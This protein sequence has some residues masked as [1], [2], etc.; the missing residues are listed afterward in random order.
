MAN[1]EAEKKRAYIKQR[2]MKEQGKAKTIG[3][4]FFLALLAVTALAC[5]PLIEI[6]GATLGVVAFWQPFVALATS[7]DILGSLVSDIYPLSIAL[8]FADQRTSFAG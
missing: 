4:F 2:I 6:E 1:K 3:F 7:Q 5:L 8:D